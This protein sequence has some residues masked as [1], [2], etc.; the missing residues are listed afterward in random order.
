[1]WI[2]TCVQLLDKF[3][4]GN[5]IYMNYDDHV[6][7]QQVPNTL[8]LQLQMMLLELNAEFQEFPELDSS[9]AAPTLSSRCAGGHDDGN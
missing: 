4:C 5:L 9:R 7:T 8:L 6:S 2:N 3:G 1:M